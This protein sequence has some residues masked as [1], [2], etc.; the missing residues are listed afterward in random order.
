MKV[1]E[2]EAMSDRH[3]REGDPAYYLIA[4]CYIETLKEMVSGRDIK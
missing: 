4:V 3:D 1:A 2:A